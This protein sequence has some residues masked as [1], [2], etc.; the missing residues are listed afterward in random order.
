VWVASDDLTHETGHPYLDGVDGIVVPGGF[1][2]RGI[3][4]KLA[5]IRYAREKKIPF[6]GLCLGLQCAVIEYSRNVLGLENANSSE[7][8]PTTPHPVIDLMID[9]QDVSNK[10]GT[11][12]LGLWVCKLGEGSKARAAY[13][14]E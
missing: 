1:G 5:A 9:Q 11:M 8:D 4:G 3:E 10:G 13:G 14:E 12:R 7:F 2:V 6:L